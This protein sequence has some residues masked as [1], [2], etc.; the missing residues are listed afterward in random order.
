MLLMTCQTADAAKAECQST[1]NACRSHR[2]GFH[3]PRLVTSQNPVASLKMLEREC[4][5]R[6]VPLS[7]LDSCQRSDKKHSIDRGCDVA[8]RGGFALFL[9]WSNQ[10]RSLA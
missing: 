4:L 6:C 9:N 7:K 5:A 8:S 3:P 10:R 1:V 2:W